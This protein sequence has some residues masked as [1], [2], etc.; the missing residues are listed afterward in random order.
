MATI[1]GQITIC[2]R[3]GAEIFRKATGEGE[4][5]GGFTR[6]NKFEPYP[7]GWSSVTIPKN[8]KA[9]S[10]NAY[11]SYLFVCPECKRLWEKTINESFL[12]GTKY[13]KEG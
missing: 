12:K 10:A 9:H 1:N 13:Y 4:A 5:D 2:D 6:W 7:D 11:D 3:C 8:G